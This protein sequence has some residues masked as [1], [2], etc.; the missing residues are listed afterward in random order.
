[1]GT[2]FLVVLI[3][4][5]GVFAFRH[6]SYQWWVKHEQHRL[7]EDKVMDEWTVLVEG[8]AGRGDKILE[9]TARLISEA[10]IPDVSVSKKMISLDRASRP[11]L[12]IENA[13]IKGYYMYVGALDYGERLNIVWYLVLDTPEVARARK[14]MKEGR[15]SAVTGILAR[16]NPSGFGKVF[17]LTI[18][19]KLELANYVALVHHIVTTQAKSL[20]DELDLDSSKVNTATRGFLNL[21]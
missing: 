3:I 11:F 9:T 19:D 4:I 14:A 1:M 21:S 6:L 15:Q 7:T 13:N 20:F 5:V 8:A 18:L 2:F 16:I 10:K 12:V 17:F